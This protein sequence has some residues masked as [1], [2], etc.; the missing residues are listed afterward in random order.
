VGVSYVPGARFYT[1]G[2]GGHYCRLAFT[3]FSPEEL[4]EGARLLASALR[5]Y[6]GAGV[7]L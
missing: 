6:P 4:A 3:L 2:D 7:R 5:E 1:D